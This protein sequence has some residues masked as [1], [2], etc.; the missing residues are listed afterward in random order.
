MERIKEAL[1]RARQQREADNHAA[2]A[3]AAPEVGRPASSGLDIAYTRTRVLTPDPVVMRDSKLIGFGQSGDVVTDAYRML[4]TRTLRAMDDNGWHSLAVTSPCPGEGKSLTAINLAMSMAREINR[5]VLLV[6]LDLR[7][8]SVHKFFGFD[9]EHGIS[10]Y[11][12]ED[13]A[14]EDV[15]INPAVERFVIL[16]GSGRV[17]NSSE[18]LNSPRMRALASELAQRYPERIV[19][20]DL[21]PVLAVDDALA[22][23]S[24]VDAFMLVVE[25]GS[26]QA[27]DIVAAHD[28]LSQANIVGTVLNKAAESQGHYYY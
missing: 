12:T 3:K 5:T 14:L 21:P 8:P 16:P 10:E 7:R 1:D 13:V 15:L 9:I 23:S 28:V 26:T 18:L 20:Y 19:I 24:L 17:Q 4:R 27:E 22:F 6:D 11:L 2:P 25:E